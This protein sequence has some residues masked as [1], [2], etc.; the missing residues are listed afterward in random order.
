MQL[1]DLVDLVDGRHVL[2][3]CPTSKV[4]LLLAVEL[5]NI[6]GVNGAAHPLCLVWAGEYYEYQLYSDHVQK[7]IQNACKYSKNFKD[8]LSATYPVLSAL[9]T[10]WQCS[11]SGVMSCYIM[12]YHVMLCKNLL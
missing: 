6:P 4:S 2:S 10:G 11:F 5:Q 9:S 1:V 8:I 3:D 7:M 12:L